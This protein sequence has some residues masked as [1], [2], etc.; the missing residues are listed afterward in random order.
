MTSREEAKLATEKSTVCGYCG[1]WIGEGQLY[2]VINDK[3]IHEECC[4]KMLKRMDEG[5]GE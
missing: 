4:M 3:K 1:K 2:H 5:D